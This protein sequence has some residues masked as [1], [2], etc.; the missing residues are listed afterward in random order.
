MASG[1]LLEGANDKYQLVT[2][3]AANVDVIASF[4]D[5]LAGAVT[6]KSPQ[7][8]NITTATTTDIVA[9]PAASTVRSVTQLTIRNKH[10][11]VATDV[12]VVLDRSATDY[13][14]KKVTLQP[15]EELH[16]TE[17]TGFFQFA[18]VPKMNMTKY[19]TADSVH[20][21]AATFADIT[22]LTFPVIA[23]R[24]YIFYAHLIAITVATTTG[25]R[26]G[27]GGVAMTSLDGG[28]V[29]PLLAGNGVTAGTYTQGRATAIDTPM[30]GAQTTGEATN[31]AH[32]FGGGFIPSASGTFAIR[33]ASE[34]T[35][36]NGLIVRKHSWARVQETDN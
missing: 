3:G 12:T 27:V 32:W 29:S 21:T 17:A 7:V 4:V 31:Q 30:T 28:G 24:S 10:A 25:A 5:W 16:Y 20:A 9:A 14:I 13:E 19:V 1:L 18:P 8:T 36:A 2:S 26:F 34:T 33:A 35:T 11:S 23:G 6:P 15:G 22:G